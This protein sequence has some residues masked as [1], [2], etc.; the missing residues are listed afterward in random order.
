MLTD[1]DLR[2]LVAFSSPSLVLSVYLNTEPSEGNAEAYKLRLRS[3]LKPFYLPQDVEAVIRYVEHEYGGQ[4]RG[5]A[6]FS[7]ADQSFFRAFP[8]ALPVPNLVH[9]SDRP[10]LKPLV[11]LFDNYGGYGVVL[12]DKQGARVFSFHLGE[13]REQ[14]GTLGQTVKQTKHG[15]ASTLTG[16]K[17]GTG[18]QTQHVDEIIERNMKEAAEF[19]VHFFE[20]NRVRR[21]LIG[22][23]DDNVT[24]FRSHLPKA[25]QSLVVD[26]FAMPMT[27]SHAE[28]LAKALA[29][30]REAEIQR[31]AKLVEDMITLAAKGGGAVTGLEE[32][33]SEVNNAK[34]Q[35]LVIEE[36]MTEVGYRCKAC[37]HLTSH[38]GK[39]CPVCEGEM[40]GQHDIV[41]LA[42]SAVMR[43]GGEVEVVHHNPRLQQAGQVGAML[44][45]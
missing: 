20:Q 35:L 25:W 8:L 18:G 32:T 42:V 17:G 12:V 34:V 39:V 23:T 21:I 38:S 6:V 16:R 40:V 29:L 24:L 22:G 2:S 10:S 33:L 43:A 19:A 45:Y 27:A 28:V 9:V 7:C 3:M 1:S 37:G 14:E 44:R 26:T 15:G 5:M 11:N 36:G 30:G 41:E 4:G 13:L 31:E